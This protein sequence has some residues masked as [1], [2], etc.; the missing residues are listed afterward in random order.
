MLFACCEDPFASVADVRAGDGWHISFRRSFGL[1]ETVEWDNL[2]RVFDLHPVQVG[3]D[4]ISWSLEA[5]GGFSSH[6]LYLKMSQGAAVTHFKEVWR[7]RVPPKIK[8]FL[9]QLIR[10]KLPSGA[11]LAKRNGPSDG[12]CALCGEWEDCNHIFFSCHLAKFLWAGVR[13]LLACSW[14]PSGIGEFLSLAQGLQ[15]PLRRLV[16]FTFAAQCWAL[17]NI[18]NKLAIE[19]VVISNP[20]DAMFKMSM[21]MQCWR[22]LVR[23]RDRELLDAA[24]EE[25]R[26]LQARMRTSA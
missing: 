24:L 10:G 23:R 14:N 16:W 2:C 11:Q 26:S 1:A 12:S 9:W 17:W 19:G 8:V 15:G 18:R 21:Y 20:A 3:Q 6:S 4:V 13:E 22:V 5:S 25:I 7:T